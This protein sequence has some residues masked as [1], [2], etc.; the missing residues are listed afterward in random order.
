MMNPEHLI[1]PPL[2]IRNLRQKVLGAALGGIL[3]GCSL[4]CGSSGSGT[5]VP[6]GQNQPTVPS[7]PTNLAANPGDA[8]VALTWSASAGAASY[9]VKRAATAG[10]PYTEV[11]A[12]TTASCTNTGLSNGTTYYYV[13]TASN[14]AGESGNSS[15]VSAKPAPAQLGTWENVTPAA[16]SLP[17][18]DF[19]AQDMLA[20][21]IHVGTFYAFVCHQGVWKSVD[22]GSNWIKVS[23]DGNLE[24][25]KP[26]GE[27][28]AP[29]GS[30]LLAGNGEVNAGAW[31]ST[32]GGATWSAHAMGDGDDPYS[33]DIDPTNKIHVIASMH[34][35]ESIFESKDGG[36]TWSNQGPSGTGVSNY[37][38]FITSTTWL[39]VA[40]SGGPGTFRSTDSGAHWTKVGGM[41]HAHGNSQI[42]IDTDH[43]AVYVGDHDNGGGIY[44][45]TN[46]GAT[47]QAVATGRP[48]STIFAT[49]THIY[50]M[51]PGANALG[52]PPSL[53]IATRS[54]GTDWV[55]SDTPAAMN[56]GAK[57]AAVAYNA[58]SGHWSILSCNWNAGFWRYVEP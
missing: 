30:Y 52:T 31:R 7:A 11:A 21:P 12:P 9:H 5:P 4:S 51:D 15:E 13:V 41:V 40:Q 39:S 42:Y 28:I 8:Q 48:S 50:S 3:L 18:S 35:S 38:F 32:D 22:W 45:S 10:G 44:R 17:T 57:R 56:N 26:W 43:S 24:R 49:A 47:F 34:G 58:T 19:G 25:G 2:A 20:D 37:V 23:T 27:A 55:F 54:L 46:A 53:Q 6:P 33:F 36:L 29:D 16:I 14:S 1:L